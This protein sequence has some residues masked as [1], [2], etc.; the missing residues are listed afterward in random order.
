MSNLDRIDDLL[1]VRTVFHC[2]PRGSGFAKKDFEIVHVMGNPVDRT[3]I[4]EW[5]PNSLVTILSKYGAAHLFQSSDDSP[6]GFRLYSPTECRDELARFRESMEM[7]A[8]YA[9]AGDADDYEIDTDWINGLQ[10]IAEVV[11]SGHYFALDTRN[12]GRDG[13]CPIV[14]LDHE[15][16]FSGFL[17]IDDA[18]VVAQT[19]TELLVKILE[20]PLHYLASH[21]LGSDLHNQWFPDSVSRVS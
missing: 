16:Y 2:T 19:A 12:R 10:P 6:E 14:F 3:D 13:E 20:D 1:R 5:M 15:Y 17:E 18:D 4:P 7:G 9:D 8:S 11:E 21:W